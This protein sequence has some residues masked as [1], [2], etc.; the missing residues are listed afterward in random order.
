MDKK[1]GS[2]EVTFHFTIESLMRD[3]LA[4]STYI[5]RTRK[6]E[7]AVGGWSDD[8]ILTDDELPLVRRGLD[9][10]FG[11][12]YGKLQA[13]VV[14]AT[15]RCPSDGGIDWVFRLPADRRAAVEE[16][17]RDQLERAMGAYVLSK[18]YVGKDDARAAWQLQLFSSSLSAV[19]GD[20]H[21]VVG[22]RARRPANYW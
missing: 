7:D 12:M 18:W 3:L 21:T 1:N 13:Y 20:I 17:L 22:R 9:E 14:A 2:E 4:E 8:W 6:A 16:V 5:A 11:M 19:L 10:A 15:A